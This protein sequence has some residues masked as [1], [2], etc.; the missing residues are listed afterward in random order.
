[1]CCTCILTFIKALNVAN[2]LKKRKNNKIIIIH[3]V[4]NLN[5]LCQATM[6]L[7]L[8]WAMYDNCHTNMDLD[9]LKVDV[10]MVSHLNNVDNNK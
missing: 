10:E 9:S 4:S 7:D 6:Q 3:L 8:R 2:K 1:M 5:C